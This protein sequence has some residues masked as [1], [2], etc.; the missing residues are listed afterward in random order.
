MLRTSQNTHPPG[1]HSGQVDAFRGWPRCAYHV[2]RRTRNAAAPKRRL[3]KL[4][5]AG[6]ARL[7]VA[8]LLNQP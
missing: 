2:P 5:G 6:A 1:L 4:D 7:S 8:I 3:S